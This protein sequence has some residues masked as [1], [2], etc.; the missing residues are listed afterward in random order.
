MKK[1]KFRKNSIVIIFNEAW[2]FL[3]QN[4]KLISKSWEQ[5]WLF[6]WG[7]EDWESEISWLIRELKEELWMEF[8]EEDF[9]FL[10]SKEF[11]IPE[12]NRHAIENVFLLKQTKKIDDFT[13]PE[14][15][16][17]EFFEF[18]TAIKNIM[19]WRSKLDKLDKILE[20]T[21]KYYLENY[22]KI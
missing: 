21:Y 2:E 1:L 6:W 12:E 18:K 7:L 11:I 16:I 5:Y 20:E 22:D 13:F 14:G 17:W 19:I 4:R 8:E 9:E 15:N 3:L 10:F